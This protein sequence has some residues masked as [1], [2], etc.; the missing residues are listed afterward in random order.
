MTDG[1]AVATYDMTDAMI[2]LADRLETFI[3]QL[4]DAVNAFHDLD[5]ARHPRRHRGRC[6]ACNPRGNRG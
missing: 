4:V 3:G 5:A 1:P 6:R 2:M